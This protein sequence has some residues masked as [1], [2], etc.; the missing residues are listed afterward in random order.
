MTAKK[1]GRK[2]RNK[3]RLIGWL[4]SYALDPKGYT[5]ELRSGR[6]LITSE[7]EQADSVLNV[8]NKSVSSPHAAMNAT[9]NHQLFIQDIFSEA[10]S[11]IQKAGSDAE[12]AIKGTTNVEH[13]DWIRIGKSTKFQVCLIDES[14]N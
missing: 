10:G 2:S 14:V 3:N 9:K 8:I 12:I 1:S 5:F 11:Y 13:G 4:V 7:T 6:S